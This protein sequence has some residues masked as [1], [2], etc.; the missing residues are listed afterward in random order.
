MRDRDRNGE[1]S[2]FRSL[3]RTADGGSID[4]AVADAQ[5][6]REREKESEREREQKRGERKR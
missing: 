1:S 3:A 2:L 6:K 5:K 4:G